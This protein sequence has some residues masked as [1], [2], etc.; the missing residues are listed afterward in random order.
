ME[1]IYV[2]KGKKFISGP[3]TLHE[4]KV[5]GIKTTEKIWYEGIPDW[6]IANDHPVLKNYLRTAKPE[7]APLDDIAVKIKKIFRKLLNK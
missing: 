7:A 1:K 6:I 2:L 4:M 3:Y 5:R